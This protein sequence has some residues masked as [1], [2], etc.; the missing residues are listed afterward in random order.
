MT[1]ASASDVK[2]RR[3]CG[4]WVG[5]TSSRGRDCL[6]CTR[7]KIHSKSLFMRS[8]PDSC[9]RAYTVN[10]LDLESA[11]TREKS[12]YEAPKLQK[13]GTLVEMTKGKS[14]GSHLDKAFPSGTNQGILTFS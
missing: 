5:V 10:G 13:L 3:K 4:A 2:T 6:L 12:P 11:M 9:V 1:A 8:C 14:T 7:T